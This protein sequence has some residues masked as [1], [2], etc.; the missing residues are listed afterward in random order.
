MNLAVLDNV[1]FG[2]PIKIGFPE[3][4][5][6]STCL[7]SLKALWERLETK[8]SETNPLMRPLLQVVFTAAFL[9]TSPTLVC[10]R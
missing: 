10:L 4:I 6:M 9:K 1:L 3:K 7:V 2:P 5:K 8:D